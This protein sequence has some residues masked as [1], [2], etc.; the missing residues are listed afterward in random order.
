MPEVCMEQISWI[1]TYIL[2]KHVGWR[3]KIK[4][5]DDV[6]AS[7]ILLCLITTAL[8]KFD[9]SILDSLMRRMLRRV[10]GWGRV[11]IERKNMECHYAPH[12]YK[13]VLFPLRPWGDAL[14]LAKC[15]LPSRVA[16]G[17]HGWPQKLHN[18]IRKK[19]VNSI[20]KTNHVVVEAVHPLYGMNVCVILFWINL[21][22]RPGWLQP[23]TG[24]VGLPKFLLGVVTL[25]DCPCPSGAVLLD[26]NGRK[27]ESVPT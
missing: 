5:L 6:I 13:T 3:L 15:R 18:A 25:L 21:A 27:A 20:L 14:S 23:R 22:R 19:I 24:M 9:I 11:R 12:E 26:S 10:V 4:F 17:Y 7:T 2:N 16:R 8:P 1:S